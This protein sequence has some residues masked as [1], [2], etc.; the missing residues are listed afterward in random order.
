MDIEK[1]ISE[2]HKAYTKVKDFL[3]QIRDVE[4]TIKEYQN[5]LEEIEKNGAMVCADSAQSISVE[6]CI[7]IKDEDLAYVKDA[8]KKK[9][10]EEID[11]YTSLSQELY[12]LAGLL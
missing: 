3:T 11:T 1:I 7:K 8:L 2:N 10:S 12:Q 5:V 6:D 9:L 4:L